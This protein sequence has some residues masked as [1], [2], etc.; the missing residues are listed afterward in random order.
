MSKLN[1]AERARLIAIAEDG[2]GSVLGESIRDRL[3]ERGLVRRC[4]G[5][6]VVVT[7]QRAYVMSPR[8]EITAVGMEVVRRWV[9]AEIWRRWCN[10]WEDVSCAYKIRLLSKA[11]DA[12]K[13][14][15]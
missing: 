8:C 5:G 6:E 2:F 14:V 4:G 9:V 12:F 3:H 7:P 1:R 15:R 13:S 11:P 10:M